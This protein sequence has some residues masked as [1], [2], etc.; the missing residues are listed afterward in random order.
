MKEIISILFVVVI[1]AI[2]YVILNALANR[3]VAMHNREVAVLEYATNHLS[4]CPT[5]RL[6]RHIN[7]DPN[8]HVTATTALEHKRDVIGE[9]KHLLLAKKAV[10]AR[11]EF[12]YL[13]WNFCC[14]SRS[15]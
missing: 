11:N 7:A 8:L 5:K 6:V 13:L 3:Y 1:L 15:W 2:I 9:A 4:R 10:D 14:R 12:W